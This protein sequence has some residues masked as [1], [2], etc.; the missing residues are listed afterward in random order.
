MRAIRLLICIVLV[1]T[2]ILFQSCE[3]ARPERLTLAVASNMQI[4]MTELT[5][6]FSET[7][8]I[9][10]EVVVGSSGKLTAQIIE[11]APFDVLLSADMFYPQKISEAGMARG[12][13]KVYARGSLILLT[14]NQEM[15]PSFNLLNEKAVKF[16]ALGNPKTAP[17]GR[18]AE[19]ALK[20]MNLDEKLAD[21]LV[22]GESI[23]QTNQFIL[24]Q[25]ADLGFTSKSVVLSRGVKE[26]GRW[27]EVGDDLYDPILQGVVV[28]ESERSKLAEAIQFRDFLFSIEAKKI[29]EKY[30]YKTSD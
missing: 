16:I 28:V 17:Y 8:G 7:T 13:P 30:G 1:F 6:I 11:G 10:C 26:K 2:Q 14:L 4:A 22:Y 9:K 29:L 3:Q 12:E 19:Q 18:A 20:S 23:S 27:I 24:S 5:E 21:K 15:S 25:V